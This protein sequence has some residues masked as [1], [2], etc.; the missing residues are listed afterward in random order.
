MWKW[1]SFLAWRW[2][3]VHFPH[4]YSS[5]ESTTVLYSFRF[6]CKLMP[7]LFQTLVC[8]LLKVA[9]VSRNANVHLVVDGGILGQCAAKIDEPVHRIRSLIIDCD[10]GLNV[11][12]PR[13]RFIYSTSVFFVLM[14]RPTFVQTVENLSTLQCMSASETANTMSMV[15]R[16]YRNPHWL[17]GRRVPGQGVL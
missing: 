17:S 13:S 6:V 10:V 2:Y 8:I 9:L 16:S 15:P 11:R 14:V 4:A 1:F 5:V 3:T 7:L 12:F